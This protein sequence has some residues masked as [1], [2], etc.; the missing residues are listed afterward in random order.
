MRKIVL[1]AAAALLCGCAGGGGEAD[2]RKALQRGAGLVELPAGLVEVSSELVIRGA[3]GLEVRGHPA[4]T[5]LR[6]SEA[7]QGRAVFV[8]EESSEVRFTA[9]AVD[10]NRQA[11]EQRVGLPPS[12]VP[13]ARFSRKN[14]LLAV[15]TDSLTVSGVEFR[16]IAGFAVLANRSRNVRI[17]TVKVEDSGSRNEIGRNNTSGGILVEGGTSSFEVRDSSFRNV[18]GNA[19]WTHS[20]YTAPRNRDGVIANNRF[21][22]IARDAIQVGHATNVR[23]ERNTGT[24]IGYPFE[25][26]DVEGGGTPVGIDTAG[27]VDRSVYADNRFEEINGKCIDLDGFH[28]GEVR[29][30]VCINR[31]QADDYPHGHYGI[32]FN[33]ANPDMESENIVVEDNEIEGTKFGGIFVIG[34]GHRIVGNRL[35][36]LNLAG[37]NENADRFGCHHFP[38]EPDLLQTGIYLGRRA[39]RPA[40]ARKNLVADNLISGHKMRTRCIAAAPGILL[41]ENRIERNR[42]FDRE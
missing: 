6:A 36:N 14:G 9:F 38:G 17:E 13:F 11:L 29:G 24:G 15:D 5:V 30:N 18:R 19:V 32:V 8:V 26:V 42:C 3:R 25:E 31:G 12:D 1:A 4:G 16:N 7:F 20:L 33:N 27:N 34:A 2:L 40:P 39:E 10:G 35:R 22:R 28:N 41:S 23:V 37:C 21:E